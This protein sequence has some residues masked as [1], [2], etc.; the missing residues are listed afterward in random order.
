M[1]PVVE[2][3]YVAPLAETLVR[4]ARWARW[5]VIPVEAWCS[6]LHVLDGL[7]QLAVWRRQKQ[8]SDDL[9]GDDD[10]SSV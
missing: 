1:A 7:Y 6:S 2:M 4:W 8:A 10:T 9:F 3:G 5:A